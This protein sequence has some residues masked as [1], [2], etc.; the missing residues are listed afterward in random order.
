MNKKHYLPRVEFY[1][2]HTCN[3]NCEGCNRFNNYAFTGH[4]R[5]KDLEQ[6]Y[7]NWAERLIVDE[8]TILGGEPM[9]NPDMLEWIVG[10]KKLWP[11]AKSDFLTNGSYVKKFTEKFYNV[12]LSTNTKLDIGLHNLHRREQVLQTVL[13]FVKHPIE[14]QR[15]PKNLDKLPGFAENWKK[16]YQQIKDPSWPHCNDYRY[17][18]ELPKNIRDECEQIHNFSPDILAEERQGHEI[19]D[20]NGLHV[21]I[22]LENFFH[23]GALIK[24]IDKNSFTLHNSNPEKAHNICHSKTCHHFMNGEL[25]KCG[26]SVL[27]KEFDRQFNL[28]LAESDRNLVYS[29]KPATNQISDNDLSAFISNLDKPIDQC[30]FCPESYTIKEIN[31]GMFKDK[32]GKKIK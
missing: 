8:Y 23:Q 13:S 1:I 2:S 4:Q 30:K 5:W 18:T 26:Q 17:W 21:V 10:L 27:F 3:F 12:L 24:Q 9:S 11:H 19:I 32:F 28:D 15:T 7:R 25:S 31:S 22:N 14:I 16:S 20:A 6:Q 29:Y